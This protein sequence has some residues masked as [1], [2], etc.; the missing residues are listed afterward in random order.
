VRQPD[1]QDEQCSK[2]PL[3][4]NSQVGMEFQ[5]LGV[6]A[7]FCLRTH[8]K[9]EHIAAAHLRRDLDVEV[10]LPRIRFRR[11]TRVGSQ[12]FTEALFPCYMFARF[13]W[14][15][16]LRRVQ[17]AQ[18]IQTVVHFAD[19]WPT[20]PAG[21]LEELRSC[22]GNEDMHRISESLESGTSV[23]I[24]GGAFH[25]LLAVVRQAL[26]ARQRVA[27]L[28][29]FLGRQ[30]CIEMSDHAI[31]VEANPRSRLCGLIGSYDP[32]R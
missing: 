18:S 5:A 28:L 26:P 3:S 19:Y 1:F 4:V 13:N 32:G 27:V 24:V 2:L 11:A 21:V 25:G 20:I 14:H 6:P 29:D 22:L 10:F 15:T 12:W 31:T 23:R 8:P 17:H 9:H 16:C 30:T 7:W